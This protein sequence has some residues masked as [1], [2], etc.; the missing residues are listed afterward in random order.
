MGLTIIPH[1]PGAD[2]EL[3]PQEV[4]LMALTPQEVQEV[5]IALF[6][7]PA[8]VTGFDYATTEFSGDAESLCN[9][10]VASPEFENLYPGASP[11][12][13]VTSV[14]LNLFARQPDG[15]GLEHWVK[16]ITDGVNTI[17]TVAYRILM[18]AN[19]A[20]QDGAIINNKVAAANEF[21]SYL[22]NH[23]E[24]SNAY[25]GDGAVAIARAWLATIDDPGAG[26]KDAAL[27]AIPGVA[28][29]LIDAAGGGDLDSDAGY[30]ND[31]ESL[32]RDLYA[33][34]T[35]KR[36]ENSLVVTLDPDSPDDSTIIIPNFYT[37]TGARGAEVIETFRGT[38]FNDIGSIE[39][40]WEVVKSLTE[41]APAINLPPHIM[42]MFLLAQREST[43]EWTADEIFAPGDAAGAEGSIGL[44]GVADP[45]ADG[46]GA[47]LES[48]L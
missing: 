3:Q 25:V 33:A 19:A 24:A 27:G 17:G 11:V 26:K 14:Y 28:E 38:G 46:G 2:R 5:Y 16:S 1:F 29:D 34:L 18:G 13:V 36:V 23:P 45:L 41:G 47:F 4:R 8:D 15:D 43:A 31:L 39:D 44:V 40:L 10:I 48:V 12:E 42:A 35:L 37:A 7:R 9:Q 20:S 21:T 22:K 30:I 32:V 6:N